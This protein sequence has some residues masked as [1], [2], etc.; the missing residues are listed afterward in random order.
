[1]VLAGG[2][3]WIPVVPPFDTEDEQLVNALV[4]QVEAIAQVVYRPTP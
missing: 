4:A 3:I 2:H 1:M